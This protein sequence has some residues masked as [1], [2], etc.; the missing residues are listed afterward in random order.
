MKAC[1]VLLTIFA[2]A[3]LPL[4]ACADPSDKLVGNKGNQLAGLRLGGYHFTTDEKLSPSEGL[5]ELPLKRLR[6][7]SQHPENDAPHTHPPPVSTREDRACR[8]EYLAVT[9]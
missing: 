1:L 3:V 8:V 6:F 9:G 2:V 7:R 5:E 4:A